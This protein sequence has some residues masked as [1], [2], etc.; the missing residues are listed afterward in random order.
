MEGTREAVQGIV[1]VTNAGNDVRVVNFQRGWIREERE[2]LKALEDLGKYIETHPGLRLLMNLE[3][4]EYLSS[5]GLGNLVGLLKKSRRS[6]SQF[7]LCCLQEPIEELF[8]VMR[9]TKI[10]EIFKTEAEA[11]KSFEAKAP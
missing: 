11:V 3:H 4:I 5:A 7:K 8:E 1:R 10:F 6:N 2:I 9:L